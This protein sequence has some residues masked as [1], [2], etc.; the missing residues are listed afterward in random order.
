M[1]TLQRTLLAF[2]LI[3]ASSLPAWSHTLR[4]LVTRPVPHQGFK[5]TAYL[6]YGHLLPVDELI[7][8]EE[9]GDYQIH[10]PSGSIKPLEKSG[11]SM[12]ANEVV[13]EEPGLYQVAVVR[14][15]LTYVSYTESSGKLGFM[16]LPKD[17]A[18]LP[19]GAKLNAS[20]KSHQFSKAV[21]LNEIAEG[22]ATPALGHALEIVIEEK[23]G[24]NGYSADAPIKARVLFQGKP[25]ANTKLSA[26]STTRNPDGVP[27]VSAETDAE[28]RASLELI[29]P[30]T[31]VLDVLHVIPSS[32]EDRHAFDNER[33]VA[34][35]AI[36][37]SD[38]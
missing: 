16:R 33:Y 23:P 26:A 29:E 1:K 12:H 4:V 10:T 9:V 34:T 19:E 35:V 21:V 11:K 6:S 37:V 22:Q 31:W 5:N 28:G 25:L 13:F 2:A 14:K 20:A 3:V 7:P 17:K 30:G 32:P 8:A 27:T 36:P 15:P 24:K 38:K 18:K